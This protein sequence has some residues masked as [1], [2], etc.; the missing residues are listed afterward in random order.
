MKSDEVV[1]YVYDSIIFGKDFDGQ[2][3]NLDKALEA[4]KKAG[5]MLNIEKFKLV[6]READFLGQVIT[7]E[8][9]KPI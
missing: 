8:G 5:L 7:P 1:N 4:F 9:I 6:N 2:L 3:K